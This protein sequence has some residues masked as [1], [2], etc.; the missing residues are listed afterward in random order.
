MTRRNIYSL[1]N[2]LFAGVISLLLLLVAFFF[3]PISVGEPIVSEIQFWKHRCNTIEDALRYSTKYRGIEIDVV[4]DSVS[5]IFDVRHDE[6]AEASEL[7]LFLIVDSTKSSGC[8][9]WIDLKNLDKYN[10]SKVGDSLAELVKGDT[11]LKK[12]I[13]VESS[14]PE[15]LNELS[16][17]GL[18]T[19]YWV[20]HY[21]DTFVGYLKF[22]IRTKLT[23]IK[24]KFNALSAQQR[25]LPFLTFYYPSHNFHIWTDDLNE[26]NFIPALKV[27]HN[28]KSVK[29]ILVDYDDLST[30]SEFK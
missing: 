3:Y 20:P 13:I 29:V 30:I 23:L 26:I 6:I 25:M 17:K 11:T 21:E 14:N 27:I 18:F 28:N 12:R 1:K 24:F 22:F 4:F 10:V 2:I 9:Y 19:S 16:K 7:S 5:Q 8:K 15:A